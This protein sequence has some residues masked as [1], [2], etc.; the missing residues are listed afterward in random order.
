MEFD[1]FDDPNFEEKTMNKLNYYD[2]TSSNLT[3]KLQ[4]YLKSEPPATYYKAAE[5]A[6]RANPTDN[7]N[8]FPGGPITPSVMRAFYAKCDTICDSPSEPATPA[9]Y[10]SL[11]NSSIPSSFDIT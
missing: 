10:V 9:E 1:L 11:F 7:P 2:T 5:Q 3:Q 6:W 4:T 8:V